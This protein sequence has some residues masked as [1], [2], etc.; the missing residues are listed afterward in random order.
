MTPCQNR[1]FARAQS[2]RVGVSLRGT[3]RLAFRPQVLPKRRPTAKE[4]L[5]RLRRSD[6]VRITF[7]TLEE[8]QNGRNGVV[9]GADVG[10]G[11][12][13]VDATIQLVVHWSAIRA[14]L[15]GTV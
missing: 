9:P 10:L 2:A 11:L 1:W 7:G 14:P 12:E 3:L 13:L 8:H 15:G 5:P 6:D 4:I